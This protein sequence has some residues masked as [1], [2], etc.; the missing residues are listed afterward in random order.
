MEYMFRI[1]VYILDTVNFFPSYLFVI[2][3]LSISTRGPAYWLLIVY[4]SYVARRT[5]SPGVINSDLSWKVRLC[6]L[7]NE[8]AIC[9]LFSTRNFMRI[10]RVRSFWSSSLLNSLSLFFSLVSSLSFYFFS[11]IV[12]LLS[13]PRSIFC[14]GLEI[15][16][17]MIFLW[18]HEGHSIRTGIRINY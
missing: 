9:S 15:D 13:S 17:R 1:L 6:V 3:D 4:L 2:Y 12:K 8:S 5:I 16:R 7:W 14:N 10:Y 11:R 18:F